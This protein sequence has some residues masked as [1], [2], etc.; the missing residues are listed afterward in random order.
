MKSLKKAPNWS[1]LIR[2][3]YAPNVEHLVG[4]NEEVSNVK[5]F[6]ALTEIKKLSILL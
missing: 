5:M 3:G 2:G 6:L 1:F 4:A